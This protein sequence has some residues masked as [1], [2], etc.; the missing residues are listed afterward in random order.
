M[1]NKCAWRCL[2]LPK[3]VT[4]LFTRCISEQIRSLH[5]EGVG[6]SLEPGENLHILKVDNPR[7]YGASFVAVGVITLEA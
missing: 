1:L 5:F 7:C 3:T 4:H 2:G 6:V